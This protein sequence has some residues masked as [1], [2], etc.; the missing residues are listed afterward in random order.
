MVFN[1]ETAL[2]ELKAR[3]K[4]VNLLKHMY[5]SEAC[6]R[7][8]A[9]HFRA[10]EELWGLAGLVHDID[11]E[12]VAGDMDRHAIEGA[13]ILKELG[14]PA[15]ITDAVLAHNNKKPPESVLEK[16]LFAAD[17]LTGLIVA[18]ALMHPS[19]KISNLDKEFVLKRFKEKRFAA[20]ASRE[21]IKSAETLGI[22]LDQFIVICLAGMTGVSG[23]LGL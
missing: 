2:S 12:I 19:K 6:L 16:A 8:L 7:R 11:L 18:C 9:V 17:P 4:N 10:D 13:G 3:V 14:A 1:R 15:E 22:S 20:G 21:Q 23:E 5:A